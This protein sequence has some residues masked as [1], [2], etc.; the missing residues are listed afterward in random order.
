MTFWLQETYLASFV[1]GYAECAVWSSYHDQG[2]SCPP[3]LDSLGYTT[4]DF[5]RAAWRQIRADCKAFADANWDD[6]KA[7]GVAPSCAGHDFWLTRN[8][9]G[10][11]YWDGDY[12]EGV[13]D[14]LTAAAH[15]FGEIDIYVYR[16][17]LHFAP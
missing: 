13:E 11:G 12:P 15:A 1:A 4:A 7:A 10:A 16:K 9:H 8:G 14:R 17:R 5:T 2:E 6:L 3:P